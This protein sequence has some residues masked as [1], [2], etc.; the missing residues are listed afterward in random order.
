MDQLAPSNIP[1]YETKAEGHSLWERC[2]DRG[3]PVV[4]IRDGE[5]GFIVRY[6]LQH[7]ERRLSES[8]LRDLRDHVRSMRGYTAQVAPRSETDALGGETGRIAGDLHAVT[9]RDAREL[10][11]RVSAFVFDTDNYA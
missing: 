6:D 10:A 9:E 3:L 7:L 2:A 5:R 4:A 11:S 8:A 1:L